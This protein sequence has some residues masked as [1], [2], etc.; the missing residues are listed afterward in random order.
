MKKILMFLVSCCLVLSASAQQ[1]DPAVSSFFKKL[2]S[3]RVELDY[4]FSSTG[5]RLPVSGSG[6]MTAQGNSFLIQGDGVTLY[7]N[8]KTL[9][10]VDDS[11]KEVVVENNPFDMSKLSESLKA[12]TSAGKIVSV[13]VKIDDGTS[14]NIDIPSYHWLESGE[15]S[16][17]EC[18]LSSFG[19]DYVVTDLTEG[20]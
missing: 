2:E 17:F 5:D 16:D 20:L 8:G 11:S 3:S 9:V 7:C 13:S 12:R 10:T 6:K 1:K 19:K 14:V 4:S 15:L 18:D